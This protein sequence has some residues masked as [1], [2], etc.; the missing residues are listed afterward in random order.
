[1]IERKWMI[2]LTVFGF[3]TFAFAKSERVDRSE[4]A[5]A[6][7]KGRSTTELGACLFKHAS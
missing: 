4:E 6:Q 3:L 1:M 5:K 2:L 7:C